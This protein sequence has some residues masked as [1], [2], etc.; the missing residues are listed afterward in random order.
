[1]V[2]KSIMAIKLDSINLFV[3]DMKKTL[4]FYSLLGF[5]FQKEEYNKDYVKIEFETVTLCFYSNEIVRKYF[6]K[7]KI[8]SNTNHQY[9][10]SFRVS[11][12]EEVDTLYKKIT[13]LGHLS[14]KKPEK[15]EW[16]QRT[17]FLIDP[18]HNL[19]EICS[20]MK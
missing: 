17:A 1:M 5:T 9:E 12:P 11:T 10:L 18:D 19:I 15:S 2:L 16:G 7:D 14:M 3:N 4:D 8:D 6:K 13:D 20:F